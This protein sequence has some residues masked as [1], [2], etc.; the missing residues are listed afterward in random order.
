[1]KFDYE[2]EAQDDGII[3]TYDNANRAIY[4]RREEGKI[5]E[6]EVIYK[7]N[8]KIS[9][10][11]R[12]KNLIKQQECLMEDIIAIVSL[13]LFGLTNVKIIYIYALII[14]LM[15]VYIA[16]KIYII[17]SVKNKMSYSCKQ[18][19][20]AEHMIYS[21]EDKDVSIDELK[22][23]GKTLLNDCGS[24]DACIDIASIIIASI[25]IIFCCNLSISVR[26]ET[27]IL[28][29]LWTMLSIQIECIY[30]LVLVLQ[31]KKGIF[32]NIV[33]P[34]FIKT[35]SDDQLELAIYG[36]KRIQELDDKLSGKKEM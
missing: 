18:Y 3:F 30:Y 15:F 24:N 19:H 32:N 6:Y 20:A 29:I 14:I 4:F 25:D 10:K 12:F 34:L 2:G 36:Y 35:P 9:F 33:Q 26:H 5:K 31:Y 8:K 13:I 21:L 23:F 16:M 27:I 11:E 1:M 7:K 22:K 17:I 28:V